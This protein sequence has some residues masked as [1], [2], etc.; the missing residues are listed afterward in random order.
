VSEGFEAGD[1]FEELAGRQNEMLQQQ[2]EEI[3]KKRRMVE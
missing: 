3:M 2:Q 1:Y